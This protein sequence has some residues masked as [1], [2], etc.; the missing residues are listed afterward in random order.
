MHVPFKLAGPYE[1]ISWYICANKCKC[2]LI[3]GKVCVRVRK[4]KLESL[5]AN[6][7]RLFLLLF[8]SVNPNNTV[9]HPPSS[10]RQFTHPSRIPS[11]PSLGRNHRFHSLQMHLNCFTTG[12][13]SEQHEGRRGLKPIPV[14]D[15]TTSSQLFPTKPDRHKWAAICVTEKWRAICFLLNRTVSLVSSIVFLTYLFLL[16]LCFIV[17]ARPKCHS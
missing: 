13:C 17:S 10:P 12:A 15:P 3:K 4:I 14:R 6:V 9:I 1:Y 8:R 7:N 16:L 2:E 5:D 11:N